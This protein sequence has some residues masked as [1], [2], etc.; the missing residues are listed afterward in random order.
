MAKYPSRTR[1]WHGILEATRGARGGSCVGLVWLFTSCYLY[2]Q[3][4][5]QLQAVFFFFV[6]DSHGHPFPLDAP[7]TGWG[8]GRG[9]TTQTPSKHKTQPPTSIIAASVQA[10]PGRILNPGLET[11]SLLHI[12][13]PEPSTPQPLGR[14]FKRGCGDGSL[15]YLFRHPSFL[16]CRRVA[17]VDGRGR[18][19][20]LGF[21]LVPEL[22]SP[23]FWSFVFLV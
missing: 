19:R 22:F 16:G 13:T 1:Q 14:H 7:S 12:G 17:R 11:D 2:S 15:L 20:A 6:L 8:K 21:A 23:F 9:C 4:V 10:S 3:I 5:A 18:N